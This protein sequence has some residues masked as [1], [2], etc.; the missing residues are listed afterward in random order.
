[1]S[2]SSV[3]KSNE[4]VVM[5]EGVDI[6]MMSTPVII[7]KP[8]LTKRESTRFSPDINEKA[9]AVLTW[10]NLTVSVT[11]NK[12]TKNLLNG[13]SGTINGGFWAIMGSSGGGK[14]TL[15]NALA[16]RLDS[17]IAMR[18][19]V[20]LNGRPYQKNLLKQMSAYVMQDDVLMAELSVEETMVFTA[21]L[22]M[23][24][25]S[26]KED[27]KARSDELLA[28]LGID[29]VKDVKVGNSVKKGISGGERK[30]LGIAMEL[31][32]RP[33]L[34]FL[35]EP[36][37]GLDSYTSLV[38]ITALTVLAKR[39]DCTVVCTIHQPQQQIYELFDNLILMKKGYIMYQGAANKTI[40]FL[41]NTIGINIP[42]GGNTA[43][44]LLDVLS[45]EK[46]LDKGSSDSL[47]SMREDFSDLEVDLT[48]GSDK[49]EFPPRQEHMWLYQFY[50]L[51][52]RNMVQAVRR[53]DLIL[54]TVLMTV[55]MSIVVS[56]GSWLHLGNRRGQIF[57]NRWPSS[58][59]FCFLTQGIAAS[60]QAIHQ[61]PLERALSI[62]E[63]SAG[64]YRSSAYFLAK[65][66]SD[67][68]V[69]M[70]NP[71]VFCIIVYPTIGYQ[72]RA[73]K[74][75]WFMFCLM[76]DTACATGLAVMVSCFCV[77]LN[78]STVVLSMGMEM[79]RV[80]GGFFMSPKLMEDFPAW[81][82]ADIVSYLK[83]CF[84]GG[85][86]SQLRGLEFECTGYEIA[87]NKC[88]I[89]RGEQVMEMRGYD[90]YDEGDMVGAAIGFVVGYRVLAYL[91]L[92]FIKN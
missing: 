51:L 43:D 34:L 59:F 17:Y 12:I 74:F 83:Y 10:K 57:I 46:N 53:W 4:E 2:Y 40:D 30:R 25:G 9:P 39:G 5:G 16:L 80:Y 33:A 54:M 23:L 91:A 65:C 18:G 67:L 35:D 70:L 14:T 45:N 89:T 86:I 92:R 50:V 20:T 21:K 26:T 79:C 60:F 13:I 44:Y 82:W 24:P 48:M 38:V 87:N 72:R 78:L 56:C 58:I 55:V 90:K 76:L 84:L 3:A 11:K 28:L 8:K 77:N 36:T 37:S 81:R 29:H 15:L 75:F 64:T 52:E 88:K 63:R 6:E 42:D 1:M 32:N 85:V 61:F 19:D 66:I 71:I 47:D 7:S 73:D 68:S 62:R 49:P 31:L 41:R 69:Q 27:R 22:R